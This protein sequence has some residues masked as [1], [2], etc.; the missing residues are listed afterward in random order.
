[1]CV[2]VRS[3][4]KF[5][6]VKTIS[7]GT[8]TSLLHIARLM[9]PNDWNKEFHNAAIICIYMEQPLRIYAISAPIINHTVLLLNYGIIAF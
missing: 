8:G 2:F 3:S 6:R 5:R 4:N 9:I 1:M 7:W